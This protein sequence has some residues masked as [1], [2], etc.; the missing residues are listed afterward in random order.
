MKK[1][2]AYLMLALVAGIIAAPAF[3]ETHARSYTISNAGIATNTKT[4]A[5]HGQLEGIYVDKAAARTGAVTVASDYDTLLTAASVTAD[6]MYYPRVDTED[7]AGNTNGIYGK[8]PLAGEVTV[9]VTDLIAAQS[10]DYVVTI[11]YS[12]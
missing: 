4:Y 5:I 12:K 11:I 3:A 2:M 7:L 8:A 9:T 1:M 10:N 6:T